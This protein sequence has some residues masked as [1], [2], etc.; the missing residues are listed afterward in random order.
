LNQLKIF[1]DLQKDDAYVIASFVTSVRDQKPKLKAKKKLFVYVRG[2][3]IQFCNL[4]RK[5]AAK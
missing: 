5:E 1:W 3:W 4:E 2:C